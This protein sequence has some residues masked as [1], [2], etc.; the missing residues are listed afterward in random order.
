[1]VRP[2]IKIPKIQG[3]KYPRN[4]LAQ[5]AS[6]QIICNHITYS[7]ERIGMAAGSAEK[8][9]FWWC[10]YACAYRYGNTVLK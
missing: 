7:T 10:S 4:S 9:G 8:N 2:T 6:K 5:T 3:N 1:M